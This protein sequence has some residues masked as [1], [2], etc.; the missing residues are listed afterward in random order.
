MDIGHSP[1][2]DMPSR[3]NSQNSLSQTFEYVTYQ[4]VDAEQRIQFEAL[5]KRVCMVYMYNYF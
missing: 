1:Y 2:L 3:K 5:L 4:E